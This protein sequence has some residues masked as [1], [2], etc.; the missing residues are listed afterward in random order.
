MAINECPVCGG[1]PF[2]CGCI[3]WFGV[4]LPTPGQIV[5]HNPKITAPFDWQ[6]TVKSSD[7]RLDS[8]I[9]KDTLKQ[10]L[11]ISK[12][13]GIVLHFL[14][15]SSGITK[16]NMGH[17]TDE[18]LEIMDPS[19]YVELPVDIDMPKLITVLSAVLTTLK[20]SQDDDD[21]PQLAI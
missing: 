20:N 21:T 10:I 18:E 12:D 19:V 17:I 3:D 13:T 9:L 14:P 8:A 6:P 15:E 7:S 16:Y 2:R 4:P 5:R 11:N 1:K